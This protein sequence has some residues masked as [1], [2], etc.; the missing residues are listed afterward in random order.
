M[1]VT[2]VAQPQRSVDVILTFLTLVCRSNTRKGGWVGGFP[3]KYNVL[4]RLESPR[5]EGTTHQAGPPV[6]CSLGIVHGQESIGLVSRVILPLV[7]VRVCR[8]ICSNGSTLCLAWKEL[9]RNK[10][11]T[12]GQIRGTRKGRAW[13]KLTTIRNHPGRQEAH[14]NLRTGD[15]SLFKKY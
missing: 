13:R 14:E 10:G 7:Q 8:C 9:S 3:G 11:D 4:T 5:V 6:S 15:Q 1:N 12:Q 2:G